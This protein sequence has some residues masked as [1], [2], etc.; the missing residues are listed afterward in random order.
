MKSSRRGL[1]KNM[2]CYQNHE[3]YSSTQS[4]PDNTSKYF[5]F[6]WCYLFRY[7][8]QGVGTAIHD[9]R[10]AIHEVRPTGRGSVLIS[11]YMLR[12]RRFE[13]YSC[14]NDSSQIQWQMIQMP[15][16][17]WSGLVDSHPG[18]SEMLRTFSHIQVSTNSL[19]SASTLW[20]RGIP[21]VVHQHHSKILITFSA[22]FYL[23]S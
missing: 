1:L 3:I 10:P 5:F 12:G 19:R 6:Q 16:S 2:V 18:G 9:V 7:S 22:F 8:S 14:D 15:S 11:L 4:T 23:S 21:Y 13:D 20:V 17:P